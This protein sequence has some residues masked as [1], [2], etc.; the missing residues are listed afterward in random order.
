MTEWYQTFFDALAH[1]VWRALVP[2][3]V[4]DDE[5]S[6]LERALELDRPGAHL[7]DVPCGE[8]RLAVRMARRGHRVT[9]VDLSTV[10]LSRMRGAAAPDLAVEAH[11]GDMRALATILEPGA[12]F[13]GAWCMGNSFGYL[14]PDATRSFVAGV[15][16]VLRP[17]ARFVVDAAMVAESVLPNMEEAD[18]YEAE[19]CTLTAVNDY[20]VRTS[21]VVS[22]MT[23]E[24]GGERSE[25]VARHRVMTCREVVDVLEHAGLELLDVAGDTRGG[26]FSLGSPRCF[27][28]ASRARRRADSGPHR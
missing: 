15:A 13:D 20:D 1:D 28:T 2:A 12:R 17:G 19:G 14:D 23:L 27:I 6:F 22:T 16:D 26:P 8:G 7:L 18:R 5:A 11:H 10:A 24:R 4:S 3:E 21:T 25:R 9:G